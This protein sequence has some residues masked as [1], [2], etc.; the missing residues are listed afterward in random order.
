[1]LKKHSMLG[2][3]KINLL[4]SIPKPV[5]P[6][7]SQEVV[8]DNSILPDT[9]FFPW[10]SGHSSCLRVCVKEFEIIDVSH[11]TWHIFLWIKFNRVNRTELFNFFVLLIPKSLSPSLPDSHYVTQGPLTTSFKCY[12]QFSKGD[13]IANRD[14]GNQIVKLQ[15]SQTASFLVLG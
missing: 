11:S 14:E 4:F 12:F 10:G 9:T 2:K 3:F 5:L 6:G 13:V 15:I 7:V 1:M 8:N